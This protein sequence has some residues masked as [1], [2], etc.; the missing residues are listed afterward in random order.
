MGAHRPRRRTPHSLGPLA[1]GPQFP[2]P[3]KTPTLCTEARPGARGTAR[4]AP[5]ADKPTAHRRWHSLAALGVP[6]GEALGR[7]RALGRDGAEGKRAAQGARGNHP[8]AL[9]VLPGEALGAEPRAQPATGGK[10]TVH[11]KW[12]PPG[13]SERSARLRG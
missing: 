5:A 7:N 1:T 2:A 8:G 11:G 10:P 6:P 13:L 12:H 3:P 4:S 9:G